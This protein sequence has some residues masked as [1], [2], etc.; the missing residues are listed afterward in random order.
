MKRIFFGGLF[1]LLVLLTCISAV[2]KHDEASSFK[3]Q[4]LERINRARQK[5]CNCGN[6]FMPPVPPLVW[7]NQLEDAARGHALDMSER[8]YFSHT[9]K[10][11]RTVSDRVIEMGY[12]YKGFK[13]F[14][15]GE[16]IA[17]GQMT[18]DEVMDGWLKSEGH[19]RNLMNPSFKEVGVSEVDHYWVQDFGGREP[20]SAREQ[21]L[22]KSGRVKLIQ[23]QVP[24]GH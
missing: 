17:Q 2:P 20:F 16:N 1:T 7:N 19:C 23:R 10:N 5:G 3:R 18:I 13:N 15:V 8:G 11:G 9:S 12:T 4:F 24:D 22:I 21:E 14:A 6:T